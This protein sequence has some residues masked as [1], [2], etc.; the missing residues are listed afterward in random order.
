M[1]EIQLQGRW[2]V[3]H[4]RCSRRNRNRR[5]PSEMIHVVCRSTLRHGFC[6]Y[7]CVVVM[8]ARD[9]VQ[10]MVARVASVKRAQLLRCASQLIN[11]HT[12]NIST[13]VCVLQRLH[14][15]HLLLFIV[16]VVVVLFGFVEHLSRR[17][18]SEIRARPKSHLADVRAHCCS[19]I[20]L[21]NCICVLTCFAAAFYCCFQSKK[22]REARRRTGALNKQSSPSVKK[23]PRRA[24]RTT[25]A[26][27]KQVCWFDYFAFHFFIFF[28]FFFPRMTD[29]HTYTHK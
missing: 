15:A 29:K 18:G 7:C 9:V 21:Y 13:K 28:F 16:V 20:Y 4:R 27:S 22:R 6:C 10:W 19:R 23:S 11:I 12:I 2:Q 17:S 8:S 1:R 5:W 3:W 25:N 26:E 24:T 14:S